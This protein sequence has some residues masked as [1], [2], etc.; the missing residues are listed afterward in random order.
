MLMPVGLDFLEALQLIAAA[1]QRVATL[2]DHRDRLR[3]ARDDGTA[4]LLVAAIAGTQSAIDR[5]RATF[6][7]SEAALDAAHEASTAEMADL[8][9]VDAPLAMATQGTAAL[10]AEG[11]AH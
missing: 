7:M 11:D 1:E 9:A 8:A 3:G 5:I 6:G 10:T 2:E 4:G